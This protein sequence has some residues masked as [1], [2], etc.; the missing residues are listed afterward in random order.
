MPDTPAPPSGGSTRFTWIGLGIVAAAAV[1]TAVV[2]ASQ[3]S[4]PLSAD[5]PV[6][7]GAARAAVA[8]DPRFRADAWGLPADDLLGFVEVPGGAFVMGSDRA[9]DP[10]AFDNERWSTTSPQS[11]VDVAPFYISR[12]EVTVAQFLAFA[13]A[14]G[15]RFDPQ[16]PRDPATLPVTFVSWP[17]ALAYGRWLGQTLASAPQTPTVLRD[18][19]HSGWQVTLPTEAEWEKAARGS[20]AR[21]YPWGVEPSAA[22]ANFAAGAP[23]PVGARPCPDCPFGLFDMSGNVW[24]WTRSPYRPYPFDPAAVGQ[25]LN[26]DAL[27]VM[28]GGSY[29]DTAQT[30]R[31]AV[32]GGADPGVRRATIG[33]RVVLSRRATDH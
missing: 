7:D 25:N 6:D 13:A 24:E 15:H 1:A 23:V 2:L 18:K 16:A 4:R 26:A 11:T 12:Y 30:I 31:A 22:F 3:T 9:T 32:R 20:D 21:R 29:A 5:R 27:W 33:F 10:L 19:L 28:R 14:T 8:A 17:D